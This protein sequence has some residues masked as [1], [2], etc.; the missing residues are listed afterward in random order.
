VLL[1]DHHVLDPGGDPDRGTGWGRT[2]VLGSADVCLHAGLSQ[3]R[4]VAASR[5]RQTPALAVSPA[6]KR[7]PK[8]GWAHAGS[9]WAGGPL[10]T[11]GNA[12]VSLAARVLGCCSW[13]LYLSPGSRSLRLGRKQSPAESDGLAACGGSG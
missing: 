13:S 9:V 2:A 7:A 1:Q 6:T 11:R 4:R 12:L 5:R 10:G 3:S 8:T